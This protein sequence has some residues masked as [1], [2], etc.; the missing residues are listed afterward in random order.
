MSLEKCFFGA[1]RR[2]LLSWWTGFARW[3]TSIWRA[4]SSIS[5]TSLRTTWPVRTANTWRTKTRIMWLAV[6]TRVLLIRPVRPHIT[7][8]DLWD[9]PWLLWRNPWSSE[10]SRAKLKLTIRCTSIQHWWV[11][12]IYNLYIFINVFWPLKMLPS[13]YMMSPEKENVIFFAS[14]IFTNTITA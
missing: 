10:T 12:F 8:K 5:A 6:I 11:F 7:R 2:T 4:C 9:S 3:C 13:K 14:F 1:P